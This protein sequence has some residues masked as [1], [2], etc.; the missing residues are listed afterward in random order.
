RYVLECCR[1]LFNYAARRRHL[2]PYA[3]NPFRALEI[4]R[5]PIHQ[6]RPIEL[7]TAEQERA[8]LEACDDWQFP[9]FLTLMLTG[10]RTG[11]LPHLRLPDDLDATAG[12]LRV[13]NKPKLGWQ[14][15]TRNEREVPLVPVLAAVLR[16]HLRGRAQGP[17]FLRWCR[18]ERAA[19]GLREACPL[20]LEQ[21]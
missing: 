20:A 12:L 2:S 14:V 1:A 15:K 7:F 9:L 6:T 4:D 3:E 13:R 21:E 16:V 18:A 8:F 17:V 10:L 19:T 5:I 11:E